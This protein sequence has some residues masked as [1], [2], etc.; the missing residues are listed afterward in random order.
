MRSTI[1][2]SLAL[3]TAAFAA[4]PLA[5]PFAISYHG[6]APV[7]DVEVA[8][9]IDYLQFAPNT[10]T[11][12]RLGVKTSARMSSRVLARSTGWSDAIS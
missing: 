4:D 12:K 2:S 3:A 9:Y 8:C 5:T 10:I 6:S 7:L 1:P 11:F